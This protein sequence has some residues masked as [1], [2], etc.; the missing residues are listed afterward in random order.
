MTTA[1]ATHTGDSV[2]STTILAWLA[3]CLIVPPLVLFLVLVVMPAV[4]LV[5]YL[6]KRYQIA[7]RELPRRQITTSAQ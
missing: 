6:R 4:A 2:G 7:R 5:Q 3:A 1:D